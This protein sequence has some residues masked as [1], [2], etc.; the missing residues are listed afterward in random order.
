M[1]AGYLPDL[2][3]HSFLFPALKRNLRQPMSGGVQ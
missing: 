2:F 3:C 1:F